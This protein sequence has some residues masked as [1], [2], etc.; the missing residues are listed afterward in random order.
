[1]QNVQFWSNNYYEN[2]TWEEKCMKITFKIQ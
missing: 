1:M 2:V